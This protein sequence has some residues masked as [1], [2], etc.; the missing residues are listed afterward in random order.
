MKSVLNWTEG[1]KFTAASDNHS[2][3]MDA[4]SPIGKGSAITPKELILAGLGGCTA[5][6]VIALMR[7]HKQEVQSFEVEVDAPTIKGDRKSVV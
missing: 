4:K 2:V 7:K 5:M 6:D 1:M 3:D